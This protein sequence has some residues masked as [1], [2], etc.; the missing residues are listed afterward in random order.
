MAVGVSEHAASR[1]RRGLTGGEHLLLPHLLLLQEVLEERL[2]AGTH[3]GL[4]ACRLQGN[5]AQQ[6]AGQ[7]VFDLCRS[8][9]QAHGS[10]REDT[11]DRHY[12]ME[13]GWRGKVQLRDPVCKIWL[14]L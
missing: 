4:Q 8:V 7:P 14:A 6:V 11:K 2:V 3:F 12:G 9:L 1:E 5:G 10:L 13:L